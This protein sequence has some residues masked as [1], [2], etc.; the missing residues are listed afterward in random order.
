MIN[1]LAVW[2]LS[3]W[4]GLTTGSGFWDTT[5]MTTSSPNPYKGY[6]FPAEIISHCVWLYY[7]FPLSYRDVEK[8]MLYW[9]IEVTCETIRESCQKFGQQY[10][11]QL[12]CQRPYIADEWHL[13]EVVVTIKKI[14]STNLDYL[15]THWECQRFGSWRLLN[16]LNQI[17]CLLIASPIPLL[18]KNLCSLL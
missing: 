14:W 1:G 8:M 5:L 17:Q 18:R 13:D 16:H 7:T 3:T 4:R 12:R 15:R 2:V 11:N 6:Q 10:A 9:G